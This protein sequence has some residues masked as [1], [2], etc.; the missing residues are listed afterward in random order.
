MQ[1]AMIINY[2]PPADA[3]G[4]GV[5]YFSGLG[6]WI[7]RGSSYEDDNYTWYGSNNPL[8]NMTGRDYIYF[9]NGFRASLLV[10]P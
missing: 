5:L 1:S 9:A 6:T 10:E 8:F 4:R 3:W 7:T 2:A